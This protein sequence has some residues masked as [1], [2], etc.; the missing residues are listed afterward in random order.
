[1]MHAGQV[2]EMSGSSPAG[3]RELGSGE[4]LLPHVRHHLSVKQAEPVETNVNR[5]QPGDLMQVNASLR[6]LA[7][8]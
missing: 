5:C 2:A 4:G 7:R 1:M 3:A 6:G 8:Q